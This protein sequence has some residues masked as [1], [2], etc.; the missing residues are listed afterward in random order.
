MFWYHWARL[1]SAHELPHYPQGSG[2]GG[3][4]CVIRH[5]TRVGTA[6]SGPAQEHSLAWL[7]ASDVFPKER[8]SHNPLWPD[9]CTE[10]WRAPAE[11]E[12]VGFG[13]PRLLVFNQ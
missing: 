11:T 8:E 7:P 10:A 1:P 3:D 5:S 4:F 12:D 6:G 9:R 13:C 2:K